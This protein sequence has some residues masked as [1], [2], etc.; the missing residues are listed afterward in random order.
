M[1][2]NSYFRSLLM[3]LACLL[4]SVIA[5]GF[6]TVHIESPRRIPTNEESEGTWISDWCRSMES[7]YEDNPRIWTCSWE[8]N[9]DSTFVMKDIPEWLMVGDWKSEENSGSGKWTIERDVQRHW[10]AGLD[11]SMVNGEE[12]HVRRSLLIYGKDPPYSLLVF[13]GDPDAGQTIVFTKVE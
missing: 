10:I 3:R 1:I 4:I 8:F 7:R 13:L 11:F 9:S 5:C 6:P 2:R 12:E